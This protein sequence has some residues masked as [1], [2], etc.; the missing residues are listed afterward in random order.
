MGAL[1]SGGIVVFNDEIINHLQIKKSTIDRV[2]KSEQEE[3]ARR[4]HLY[5]GNKPF[6]HLAGK[7]I[8][9]IDDGIATGSTM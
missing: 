8:I 2:I 3:L 1:A 4:E 5:R 7:T 9:L 6:P